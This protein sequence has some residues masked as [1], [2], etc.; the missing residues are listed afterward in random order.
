MLT[1]KSISF[2]IKSSSF[3]ILFKVGMYR[4][5]N[6][7]PKPNKMKHWG[8]RPNTEHCFQKCSPPF[9]PILL[10][11]SLL[12]KLNSQNLLFTLLSCFT[13]KNKRTQNIFI[14][15]KSSHLYLYSTF[16][17]CVKATAQYQNRIFFLLKAFHY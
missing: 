3:L 15:A 16:T 8:R 14:H 17:N 13:K 9:R 5:E 6:S 10:F 2:F 1:F 4:N 12:H 7:W 11:F